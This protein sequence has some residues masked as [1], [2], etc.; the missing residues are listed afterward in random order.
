M[1]RN[2]E[3]LERFERDYV[4]RRYANM[5]YAEALQIFAALWQHARALNPG[6]PDNWREDVEADIEL[7]RVLNGLAA[8]P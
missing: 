1:I 7:A 6:F 2:S 3:T 4:R 8:T 5:T